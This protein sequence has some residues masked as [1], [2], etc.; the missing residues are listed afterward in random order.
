MGKSYQYLYNLVKYS[1]YLEAQGKERLIPAPVLI[2][3]VLHYNEEDIDRIKEIM[4][5][6]KRG[7]MR[8]YNRKK[9]NTYFRLKEKTERLEYEVKY[10]EEERK[11]I[12]SRLF[13]LERELRDKNEDNKR[14]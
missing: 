6:I 9:S 4:G 2:N 14:S 1:E 7:D 5:T 12:L 13:A 11:K 3:N 10:M 8:E